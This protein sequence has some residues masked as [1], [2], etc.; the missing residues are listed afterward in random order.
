[1]SN[2]TDYNVIEIA[3]AAFVGTINLK[4]VHG[5]CY[6]ADKKK[7][8]AAYEALNRAHEEH[9]RLQALADLV[10]K[11]GEPGVLVVAAEW[12]RNRFVPNDPIYLSNI[13]KTLAKAR[14]IGGLDDGTD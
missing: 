4:L 6:E 8:V 11:D 14:E 9:D 5:E 10:V 12:M 3:L 2:E 13:D 7:A 1:M